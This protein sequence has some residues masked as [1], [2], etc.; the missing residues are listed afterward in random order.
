[1]FVISYNVEEQKGSIATSEIKIWLKLPFF[2][3]FTRV[4]NVLR[5]FTVYVV[6]TKF[7]VDYLTETVPL[8]FL[9]IFQSSCRNCRVSFSVSRNPRST[10]MTRNFGK[11]LMKKNREINWARPRECT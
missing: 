5:R 4:N 10:M 1:M 7:S 6:E 3:S 2:D 8:S 9:G 11:F